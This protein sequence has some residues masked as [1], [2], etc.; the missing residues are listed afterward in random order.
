MRSAEQGG[1]QRV[2]GL[3]RLPD[4]ATGSRSLARADAHSVSALQHLLA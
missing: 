1:L 3:K 2:V 4:V